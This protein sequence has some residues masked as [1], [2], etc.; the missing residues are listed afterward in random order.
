MR[1]SVLMNP[2]NTN[3]NA[4]AGCQNENSTEN[5]RFLQPESGENLGVSSEHSAHVSV[6]GELLGYARVSTTAQDPTRQIEGLTAAG[7]SRIF[8]DHGVSGR[9]TSRPEFD[10]MLDV[11][12]AGDTIVCVEL[13]R[14][15]R[16]TGAVVA[17]VEDLDERRIGLKILNIG[18]DSSTPTGR[19]L[20]S[21]LAAVSQLEVDLLS[22][23]VRDGLASAR[24]QGRIG[25]R[26]P[27]LN[28][29]QRTEALRLHEDGRSHSEIAR[30]FGCS[31]RTVYRIAA[32]SS[33]DGC[34]VPTAAP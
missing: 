4:D 24:R 19:L 8:T 17:L 16:N 12:R 9:K 26:K 28:P 2:A 30:L 32:E 33:D 34:C 14:L 1:A 6:T 7:C 25:G 15:G 11:A 3:V 20:V 22:E 18:L 23:R 10:R 27:A 5:P 13:S 21:I 31:P 29:E